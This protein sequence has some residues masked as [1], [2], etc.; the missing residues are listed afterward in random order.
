MPRILVILV[1]MAIALNLWGQGSSW[2]LQGIVRDSVTMQPVEAA[3]VSIVGARTGTMTNEQ[4]LFELT[5]PPSARRLM[6][7][8]LG[9]KRRYVSLPKGSIKLVNVELVPEAVQ[10]QEVAVGRTKEHY[11]KRNNPAV[12][13]M[14]RLRDSRQRSDPAQ[15]PYYGYDR[16]Q[17]I[18]LALNDFGSKD[19]GSALAKKFPFLWDHVDTSEVSGKPILPFSLREQRSHVNH[20]AQP[21]T[22]RETVEGLRHEGIDDI[23]DE[24]S[25]RS[26]IEDAMREVDVYQNDI[27]LLQNRFVSPLGRLAADFYKFYLTDTVTIGADTCI[28][29]SFTPHNTASFGFVGQI[30][31]VKDDPKMFIR[32][33]DMRLPRKINLNFIEALWLTQE[34]ERDPDDSTRLKTRDDMVMEV[35]LLPGTPGLYMRRNS[36]FANHTFDQPE[37]M[38]IFGGLAT[39]TIPDTAYG[40]SEEYW[41]T[42][43]LCAIQEGENR[44]GSLV[45]RLRGVKLYRYAERAVKILAQGYIGTGRHGR[46]SA[47]DIGPVNTF[48]SWGDV[49][50]LRLRAGGMTTSHL[51]KHFFSRFYGAYG[52]KD[53][54]WKY[55]IELE[56]AFNDKKYHSREWP[57]HS[58][59]LTH[60]YDLDQIGQHYDFTS[61]DNIFLSLKREKDYLVTYNRYTSLLYTLELAN[62]LSFTTEALTSQQWQSPWVHF[63]D[64]LGHR[65]SHYTQTGFTVTV[66]WAPGEKFFQTRTYRFPVNIDHPVVQLSHYVSPGGFCGSRFTINRTE[67]SLR[68]RIWFSA[69]GYLDAIVKGSH[70]WS[71]APFASLCIPNA[72]LSYTIQPESFALLSPMEFA[73]D[74]QLSWDLNYWGN[75]VLFNLIPGFKRLKLREVVAFRG[76]WDHLSAKNDP[77]CNPLTFQWPEVAKVYDMRRGPYMEM[78]VGVDNLFRCLR[79]DWTWR[80]NY[81]DHPGTSRQ[82]LRVALH[83]TF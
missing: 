5:V 46:P 13:L 62:H 82:G 76:V 15:K 77:A 50:G 55:N 33:V 8:C 26:F 70:V 81:R 43:R 69:F 24:A 32:R 34:W 52:F 78:A 35:R 80:L 10:L 71:V 28:M 68:H 79:V 31:V 66:R 36:T 9:Y 22:W 72:N 83:V 65:Y 30:Y 61:Q 1:T 51:S 37:D 67:L 56:W 3:S 47:F 44:V 57:V 48:V 45:R 18:T 25:M 38:K 59:R 2:L 64:G 49:E 7:T 11:S 14:Q 58:L 60:H 21:D 19:D 23:A 73:G 42:A 29:L 17:R 4:G 75:G 12:N 54:R 63:V 39:V 6:V 41:Q 20:R 16:Y 74:S 27:T 40:R 53:H